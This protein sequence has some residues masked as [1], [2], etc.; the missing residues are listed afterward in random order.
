MR[1]KAEKEIGYND[2]KIR[3]ILDIY[4]TS[5]SGP[6]PCLRSAT[7]KQIASVLWELFNTVADELDLKP[8]EKDYA[9]M[10]DTLRL[11]TTTGKTAKE[12]MNN[13]IDLNLLPGKGKCDTCQLNEGNFCELKTLLENHRKNQKTYGEDYKHIAPDE[14]EENCIDEPNYN[15]TEI[16]WCPLYE[17]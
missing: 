11:L 5:I 15:G 10:Q 3:C 12:I 14:W 8:L 2:S 6:Q 17:K 1:V 13:N 7:Q 4:T 9:H 16:T